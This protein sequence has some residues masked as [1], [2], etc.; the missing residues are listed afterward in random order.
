ME[1]YLDHA[2]SVRAEEDEIACPCK[3]CYHRFWHCRDEVY[4]HLIVK[5]VDSKSRHWHF[6]EN[7]LSAF[8]MSKQR[9]KTIEK[10]KRKMKE[11]GIKEH[12]HEA[13]C[14]MDHKMR[15][16][17]KTKSKEVL[18]RDVEYVLDEGCEVDPSSEEDDNEIMQNF[19]I[20]F[21]EG[22]AYLL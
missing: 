21:K 11:L 5:G 12:A 8:A 19:E 7:F 22:C 17:N 3:K 4:D 18:A 2:F 1:D 15:K 13:I 9:L 10:N 14:S 16:I 6:D 20:S